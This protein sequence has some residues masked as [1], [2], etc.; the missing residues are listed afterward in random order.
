MPGWIDAVRWGFGPP[1]AQPEPEPVTD[2]PAAPMPQ[3]VDHSS[4]DPTTKIDTDSGATPLSTKMGN[5]LTTTYASLKDYINSKKD[6][7]ESP[8]LPSLD[9]FVYVNMRYGLHAGPY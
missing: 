1:V 4:G 7:L 6:S 9:N 2:S 8:S 3:N 5:Q